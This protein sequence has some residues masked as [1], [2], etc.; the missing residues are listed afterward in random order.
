MITVIGC[1][2]LVTGPDFDTFEVAL[3]ITSKN[4]LR[5]KSS[6]PI[7]PDK[8]EEYN[9]SIDSDLGADWPSLTIV[10]G[11]SKIA[12]IPNDISHVGTY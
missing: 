9:I 12:I 5:I 8:I 1:S 10:D 3:G 11:G 6:N 7:C 4:D 2:E